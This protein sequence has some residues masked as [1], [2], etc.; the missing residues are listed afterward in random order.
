MSHI[1]TWIIHNTSGGNPAESK[2]GNTFPAS[3]STL[4]T[5]PFTVLRHFLPWEAFR[6]SHITQAT[7][8]WHWRT[9]S[10]QTGSSMSYLKFGIF[11]NHFFQFLIQQ[12]CLP[13]CAALQCNSDEERHKSCPRS[14]RI[15]KQH[16]RLPKCAG[17]WVLL[18]VTPFCPIT[19]ILWLITVPTW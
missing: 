13:Q 16:S 14:E 9:F 2:K 19:G 3:F 15:D 7:W 4:T 11:G 10:K 6:G 18:M 1:I 12:D 17:W 8:W 5:P